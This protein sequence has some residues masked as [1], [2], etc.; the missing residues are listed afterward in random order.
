[1]PPQRLLARG[2]ALLLFVFG[3]LPIANLLP[4]GEVDR[5][6]LGRWIDWGIGSAIC[7]GVAMVAVIVWRARERTRGQG[8]A[9]VGARAES[10]AL[11]HPTSASSASTTV[12]HW[13]IPAAAFALYSLAA[14]T[15]FDG[16]PLLIDELVQV[17]QARLYA[18][19][20]LFAPVERYR[21]FFS[22]L[23][24]V[25]TGGKVYSQFPPGGPAML[26]LGELIGATW[27][28]G[29]L[30]GALCVAL[31]ARLLR[32]TDPD[33]SARWYTGTVLLFAAAPFGVF[34]FGS[35][36]N[37]VTALLFILVAVLAIAQLMVRDDAKGTTDAAASSPSAALG[38][39]LLCGFGLGAAATI[40]P[41]DAFAFALPAGAWF[42]TRALRDRAHWSEAI[43][44]GVGVAVP[45][46]AMM[47]VNQRTT[48][49]PLLFGYEV[50][51]GKSHGLGF[52]MA[53]WGGSHTPAR[54]LELISLYVTRLQTYLFET[55]FPAL[56]PAVG[57]LWFTRRLR[58]IDQYLLVSAALLGALYFAYWHDGFF[59][60][61]RFVFPWL[62]VLVLLS[63]RAPRLV[64][65]Q[66]GAGA[67]TVGVDAAL[68]A[69]AVM[70]LTF[71]LPVRVAQYR[72]GLSSMRDD[73]GALAK[74]AGAERALVFV[75]ESWGAELVARLWALDVSRSAAAAL[76]HDVDA[77]AL[78]RA[79]RELERSGTRGAGAERVLAPLR[80]DSALV[81]GSPFSP[82]STE[83][84]RAGTKYDATCVARLNEDRAGY[85]LLPP[86]LLDRASGNVYA[87][88]LASRDTLLMAEYP[89]RPVYLMRRRAAEAGG[90]L[91]WLRLS[92]D[93]VLA[94]WRSGAP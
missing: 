54:G 7:A 44:S 24:V 75:R 78:D 61:P 22:V 55:P 41:L 47:Y 43:A 26:A 27:L 6:Y 32:L 59:L 77:C 89:E 12:T 87:R 60:G 90:A 11:E 10:A 29:P 92:R 17:M 3:V 31:F 80:A 8:S 76:Y 88:D 65:E 91:E 57:A 14:L 49:S 70:A 51:W 83:R 66:F 15:V 36:M 4:G 50:L 94:S 52:H 37:H 93:S 28:V 71:A 25:D 82:D 13:I 86:V 16:R 63:A 84:F 79:I 68:V 58:A 35:H 38:T 72:S 64:R 39:A 18:A 21:E 56:L 1:M 40:R 69:G 48:G 74:A 45:F 23:H 62:P 34:M 19:G 20:S 46:A 73:Y 33:A 9:G 53:P 67:V 42:L 5:G 85:A 30:C 81:K 2:L